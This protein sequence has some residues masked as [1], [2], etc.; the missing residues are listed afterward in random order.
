MNTHEKKRKK[1]RA[2]AKKSFY[3]FTQRCSGFRGLV[4]EMDMD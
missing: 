3:F 2:R 1:K 4:L